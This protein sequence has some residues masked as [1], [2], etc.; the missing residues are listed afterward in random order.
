MIRERVQFGGNYRY[1][2]LVLCCTRYV[3]FVP[4]T[5]ELRRQYLSNVEIDCTMIHNSRPGNTYRDVLLSGRKAYEERGFGEEFSKHHQGGPIGY[6]ARDY[7]VGFSHEGIIPPNQAFCWNPS[8]TG[9]K[10]EDTV[11]MTEDGPLFLTKPFVYPSVTVEVEGE[12]YVR[13]DI[14]V[15]CF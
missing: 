15:K 10:S 6:A 7:R 13:P 2:G 1:R 14:L 4:L 12:R 11:V 3:N 9:T 8:I 5:D